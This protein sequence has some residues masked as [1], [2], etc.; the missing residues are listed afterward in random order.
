M[1]QVLIY[2]LKVWLSAA[3]LAPLVYIALYSIYPILNHGIA[4]P[5]YGMLLSKYFSGAWLFIKF[6]AL[7]WALIAIIL[8][9]IPS[10]RKPSTE[11]RLLIFILAEIVFITLYHF[12]AQP[13]ILLIRS[14]LIMQQ[15]SAVA[16]FIFI[17]IYKVEGAP[18]KQQAVAV[19]K[20]MA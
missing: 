10:L 15:A 14:D 4:F 11:N 18:A 3:I 20:K 12:F 16:T 13:A 6:N 19:K 8:S 17:F 9:F 5:Q 2:S 1:K 7:P